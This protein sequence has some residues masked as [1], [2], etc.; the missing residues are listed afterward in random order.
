MFQWASLYVYLC[1]CVFSFSYI[2]NFRFHFIFHEVFSTEKR[3]CRSQGL[4]RIIVQ[5][6]LLNWLLSV[7]DACKNQGKNKLLAKG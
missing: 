6:E 5:T 3:M 2:T 1:S 7:S 4:G